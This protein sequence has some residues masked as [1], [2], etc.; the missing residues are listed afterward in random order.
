MPLSADATDVA[1]YIAARL[2]ALRDARGLKQKDVAPNLGVKISQLSKYETAESLIPIDRLMKAAAFFGVS[3]DGFLPITAPKP[4]AHRGMA[5][6]PAAFLYDNNVPQASHILSES[7]ALATD[8]V[9]IQSPD[10]R[11]SIAAHVKTL[12]SAKV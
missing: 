4:A 7:N 5:D 9:S 2:V 3:V 10:I 11:A 8:F 12:A 6:E 1:K